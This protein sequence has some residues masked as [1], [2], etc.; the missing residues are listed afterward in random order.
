MG[1][2]TMKTFEIAEYS[3]TKKITNLFLTIIDLFCNKYLFLF[4]LM[5]MAIVTNSIVTAISV[6]T[7]MYMYYTADASV[8]GNRPCRFWG[9]L[10]ALYPDK[11]LFMTVFKIIYF[12]SMLLISLALYLMIKRLSDSGKKMLVI[13]AVDVPVALIFQNSDRQA[14]SL[15]LLFSLVCS[16]FTWYYLVF[17]KGYLRYMALI[18]AGISVLVDVR[19]I[20]FCVV[21]FLA[22]LVK[23]RY[24]EKKDL[25]IAVITFALSLL[26]FIGSAIISNDNKNSEVVKK[27]FETHYSENYDRPDNYTDEE[28]GMYHL[29]NSNSLLL[30]D[31]FFK[32]TAVDLVTEWIPNI[33]DTLISFTF[34][35]IFQGLCYVYIPIIAIYYHLIVLDEEKRRLSEG[36]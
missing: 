27:Y 22:I 23:K 29:S 7:S 16:L 6:T 34:E 36:V 28:D 4:I 20:Y 35:D 32:V 21:I 31:G 2:K 3:I 30:P 10:S 11:Y 26:I 13:F 19:A 15:A 9:C 25:M 12:I 24:T 5:N 8:I 17:G 14:L 33:A 1:S 18:F